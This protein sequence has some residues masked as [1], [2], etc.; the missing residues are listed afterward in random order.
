MSSLRPCLSAKNPLLA[1][2]VKPESLFA[3]TV[4]CRHVFR[5]CALLCSAARPTSV[6]AATSAAHQE[7][8]GP[9]SMRK[10][11]SPTVQS[12][13]SWEHRHAVPLQVLHQGRS[14]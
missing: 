6:T 8:R 10:F 13:C 5:P 14:S 9:S 1:M 2:K 4:P 7:F 12:V 3:S 11:K